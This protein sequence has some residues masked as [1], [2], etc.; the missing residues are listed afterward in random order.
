[1]ELGL[2]GK[3]AIVTGGSRGIGLAIADS[4][5][6]EGAHVA[7]I[8]RNTDELAR[9]AEHVGRHATRVVPVSTDTRD[10]DAVRAM[11]DRVAGVFGGV[12]ILV[13]A[14]AEPAFA[15][16]PPLAELTDD[17]L[18][19]EIE[20]KVLGY[21]RCIR[22]VVPHMIAAGWGRVVNI[23]GLAARR[24]GALVGTVRNVS[25][26]GM[27]KNLADEL[28]PSG[29]TVNVVHPGLTVTERVAKAVADRAASEGKSTADVI[30]AMARDVSIGRL[31]TSAELAEVVTFLVSERSAA[32]NGESI[33]AGGGEKGVIHY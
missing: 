10:D 33:D 2:T 28:G 6:A 24:T 7:L 11:V 30:A 25:V 4:L 5:A 22:A 20:T 9:A 14:A 21:L 1:M 29:I 17:A 19:A 31:V 18:R 26:A 12:D 27:T 3:R 15:A 8:A 32:I 16:P 13:N 23:A